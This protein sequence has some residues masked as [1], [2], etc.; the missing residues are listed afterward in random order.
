MKKL[1]FIIITCG[2]ALA[3][4][5]QAT[6]TQMGNLAVDANTTF[7]TIGGSA[8]GGTGFLL[9][10][11]DGTTIWNIGGEAGYFLQDNLAAKVGLGF[12][13]FDGS[14]I[15]SY[16]IGVKYYVNG[17]IPAQIDFW[18]Q[19]GDDFFPADKPTF[20]GIQAGYAF[21]IGEIVSFEPSLRY[22]ISM[23]DFDNIFQIQ[24]GFSVF[25]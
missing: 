7:G 25:F 16:K 5:S 9:N 12:G 13:D 21:F 18:G 6:Q 3:G 10:N 2:I 19:S 23:N 8:L 20:I 15:F 24:T 1:L 17:M 4:Y 22:N 11:I 14:T